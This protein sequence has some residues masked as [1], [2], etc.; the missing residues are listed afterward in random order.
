MISPNSIH[1]QSVF[2]YTSI[3][4]G[5]WGWSVRT[6]SYLTG[7]IGAITIVWSLFLFPTAH[8]T[9]GNRRMIELCSYNYVVIHSWLIFSNVL[10]R[11]GKLQAFSTLLP[12][13]TASQAIGM[14]STSIAS[15]LV[16]NACAPPE[17]LSKLYSLTYSL[18]S[19]QR[20]F[21]PPAVTTLFA[22][23]VEKQLLNGY[24]ASYVLGAIGIAYILLL[25]RYTKRYM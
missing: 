10:L 5:G 21:T 12:I 16:F 17:S 6:I 8:K 20:I 25:R 4:L 9:L 13:F 7:A 23:S 3:N 24:L 18:G 2:Y 1:R 22:Y 15:Q 19:F 11:G 14:A